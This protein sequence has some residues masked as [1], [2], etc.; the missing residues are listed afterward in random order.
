ML[1]IGV[2]LP[3]LLLSAFLIILISKLLKP[4]HLKFEL[5]VEQISASASLVIFA[6][7]ASLII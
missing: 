2:I 4:S 3:A 5:I 6:Y 1:I 7:F